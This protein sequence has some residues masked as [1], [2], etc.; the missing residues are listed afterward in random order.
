MG[1]RMTKK[2]LLL[3]LIIPAAVFAAGY[4]QK[5]H[6]AADRNIKPVETGLTQFS[7]D[8]LAHYDGTDPSKP[9]Y[10]G[11]NGL[12]YDVSAGRN[13]YEPNGTYHFL[14]GKD[15]SEQLNLIGGDIIKRKYPV[16]GRLA[17]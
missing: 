1:M 7:L 13:Y 3:F 4:Y 12:V 11:L 16:I 6:Q 2:W 14:A 10:I 17:L 8:E 9:I 5:V 15:S